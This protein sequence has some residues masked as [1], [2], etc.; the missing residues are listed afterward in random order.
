MVAGK[1]RE[2]G[3]G[4][5]PDVNLAQARERAHSAR[6]QIFGGIAHASPQLP[7]EQPQRELHPER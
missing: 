3:L 2:M 6:D 5:Y 7:H 1:R 4:G